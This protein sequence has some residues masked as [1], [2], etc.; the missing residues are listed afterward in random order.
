VDRG[1]VQGLG[2]GRTDEGVRVCV[3][4]IALDFASVNAVFPD[5]KSSPACERLSHDFW[6]M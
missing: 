4:G 2:G 6:L 1:E 3:S 5:L